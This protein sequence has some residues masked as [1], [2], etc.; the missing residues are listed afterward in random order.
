M[1]PS[2]TNTACGRQAAPT[3]AAMTTAAAAIPVD[4]FCFHLGNFTRITIPCTASAAN[5]S[6]QPMG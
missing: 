6:H 4:H 1:S 2:C 5:P 3:D